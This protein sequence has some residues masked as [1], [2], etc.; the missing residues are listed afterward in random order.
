M[1]RYFHSNHFEFT[2]FCRLFRDHH[3]CR[4]CFCHWV[5][6]IPLT[7]VF[8]LN[9]WGDIIVLCSKGRT[10]NEKS[11]TYQYVVPY[12]IILYCIVFYYIILYYDNYVLSIKNCSEFR[13]KVNC[14]CKSKWFND[15]RTSLINSIK[16]LWLCPWWQCLRY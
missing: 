11:N 2:A 15:T 10:L 12:P 7:H 4:K 5:R 9:Q 8:A 1:A 6:N 13:T 3:G 14:I 16:C